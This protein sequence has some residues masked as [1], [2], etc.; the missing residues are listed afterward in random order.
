M[1]TLTTPPDLYTT[2]I[3]ALESARYPQGQHYLCAL[4]GPTR[5]Y[6]SLGVLI[7]IALH[8]GHLHVEHIRIMRDW[9]DDG[10]DAYSFDGAIGLPSPDQLDTLGIPTEVAEELAVMNDDGWD[11]PAIADWLRHHITLVPASPRQ[12]LPTS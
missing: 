12:S 2:W 1:P 8:T 11:F 10:R 4:T 5:T 9:A 6:C 3:T 7:D